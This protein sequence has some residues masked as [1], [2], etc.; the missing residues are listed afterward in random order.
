M[1]LSVIVPAVNEESRI[2]GAVS[3]AWAAGAIEVIVVDGGSQDETCRLAVEAGARL[4]SSR[5]RRAVQQNV[6]ARETRGDVLLFLHA[7]CRLPVDAGAQVDEALDDAGV[8]GGAF[9]QEIDA[10]GWLFR[11]LERG[12]ARRALRRQVPYGDQGLFVRRDCFAAAGG[13]PVVPLMD[14][15]MLAHNLRRIGRLALVEGPLRVDARRWRQRGVIPQTLRN[16]CLLSAWRCGVPLER[17]AGV[18]RRH[19]HE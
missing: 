13:F 4:I 16:W 9:R 19:D 14:D 8:V 12:N 10:G 3:S 7:D 1:K 6:G 18:Y 11:W 5:P 2:T 15:V 17:L